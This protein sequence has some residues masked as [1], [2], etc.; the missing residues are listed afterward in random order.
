MTTLLITF[1]VI[2]A[3]L[4]ILVTSVQSSKKEG[5]DSGLGNTGAGQ[6]IG[7]K[8]TGDLL[9]QTTWGLI[10]ILFSLSL[11]SA[12]WLKKGRKLPI[13]PNIERAQEQIEITDHNQETNLDAQQPQ[14]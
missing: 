5:L 2:S 8:K 3:V 11:S 7:V 14:E 9:E 1:I 10:I 4:L 6:L 12:S 13:S